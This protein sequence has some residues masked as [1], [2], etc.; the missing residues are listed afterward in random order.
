MKVIHL[1]EEAIGALLGGRGVLP[2]A[3]A[4]DCALALGSFDGLHLGHLGLLNALRAASDRLGL[5]AA[6][7][8]FRRHPRQ[9]LD[10][11]RAPLLLTTWRERLAL[12]E[13]DGL[14]LLVAADFCPS[15]ARTPYDDFVA[16][17]LVRLLRMRHLIAGHDTHLGAGRGGSAATLAALGR[18]LD[19]GFEIVPPLALDGRTISSS[20]IRGLLAEGDVAG[21]ARLLGRPYALWGEVGPGDG[22]G[23]ALGF[24]TA[25]LTPLEAHK[26]LPA[27]GVYA[28]RV[29][30]PRDA[31]A[32]GS[33]PEGEG[34]VLEGLPRMDEQGRL[35]D[36]VPRAW[37]R[38][39]A[40][41][42]HGRAPTF[43]RAPANPRL[44]VHLLDFSG[45]LR[46]RVLKVEW[47]AR[48][49]EERE[50]PDPRALIEQLERDAQAARQVLR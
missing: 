30:A 49:R 11:G 20:A 29:L 22:R 4:V 1:S 27:P 37:R 35:S 3:E 18:R 6:L 28:V 9:L 23:R 17:F 39:P 19:F 44:E 46:G 14:D 47:V 21:A 12:F 26:L 25:N 10:P 16:L 40:M 24:P 34:V 2:A 43:H 36:L 48:L 31:V 32:T 7:F 38:L 50:F 8:T 13:A 33:A 45:D 15:L 42:N 5:A 41:L